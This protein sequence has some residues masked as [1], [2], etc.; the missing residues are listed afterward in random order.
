MKIQDLAYLLHRR[1]YRDNS[2]LADFFTQNHGVVTAVCRGVRSNKKNTLEYFTLYWVQYGIK[3]SLAAL[4]Q[5]EPEEPPLNRAQ[6]IGNKL[7]CGLYLNE[8]LIKLLGKHDPYTELF[9]HYQNA[10]N[11]IITE[12]KIETALRK[13]EFQLLKA[14]GYGILFEKEADT[15]CSIHP[16]KHY[17]YRPGTGF[18]LGNAKAGNIQLFSGKTIMAI[19]QGDFSEEET[20]KDAKLLIRLTFDALF[21]EAL[22]SRTLFSNMAKQVTRNL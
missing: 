18:L 13:F 22:K 12:P 16:E 9:Q 14:A 15:H 5:F 10:L 7:Y 19:S 11:G 20:L 3:N 4:Y 1:P 8:L 2:Y 17:H 21:G 6:M